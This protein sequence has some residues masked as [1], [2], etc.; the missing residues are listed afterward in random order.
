MLHHSRVAPHLPLVVGEEEEDEGHQGQHEDRGEEGP[1]QQVQLQP[2]PPP[3]RR[4]LALGQRQRGGGV[5]NGF[6]LTIR[7]LTIIGI[8]FIGY[9]DK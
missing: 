7:L 9:T 5:C 2:V 1:E 4:S 3:D 8:S 6:G